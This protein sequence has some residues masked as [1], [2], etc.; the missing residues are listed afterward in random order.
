MSSKL[1]SF[2]F[3][4]TVHGKLSLIS[5]RKLVTQLTRRRLISRK[6]T[7]KLFLETQSCEVHYMKRLERRLKVSQTP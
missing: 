3:R 5:A 1:T 2:L 6:K 7:E 4:K